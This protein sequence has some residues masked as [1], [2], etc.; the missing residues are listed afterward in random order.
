MGFCT[1]CGFRLAGFSRFCTGCGA[2]RR[3]DRAKAPGPRQPAAEAA[4]QLK[5]RRL[6]GGRAAVAVAV[7]VAMG[8]SVLLTWRLTDHRTTGL[9]VPAVS[10]R[11][12]A[13]VSH[14]QTSASPAPAS[15]AGSAS[16]AAGSASAPAAPA[17]GI[18]IGSGASQQASAG[19]VAVFLGTY[20]AAI[21]DHDYQ[22]YISLFEGS[23][24]PDPSEQQFID[25]YSTTMDMDPVLAT[26]S[27]TATSE[28]AATVTFVSH[29][30]PAASA[31]HSWCTTWEITLYLEPSGN[32][33]LI[34]S[35]PPGY[36]ASRAGC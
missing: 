15:P 21:N 25:G 26:L 13:S 1:T 8:L 24:Q 35:P 3:P 11:P 27:R 19:R 18:R 10:P 36:Q 22:A 28:W 14:D 31:T 12:T 23:A 16:A 7:I 30:S 20:F 4:G 6:P 29:Q 2:L 32:S 5:R 34:G 17:G 9:A 33:Y